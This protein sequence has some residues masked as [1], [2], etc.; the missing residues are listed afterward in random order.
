MGCLVDLA[1]YLKKFNIS[2]GEYRKQNIYLSPEGYVKLY[3][4]DFD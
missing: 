3:L 2:V 4:L 1:D